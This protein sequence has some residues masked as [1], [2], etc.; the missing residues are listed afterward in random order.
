MSTIE[1]ITERMEF[2]LGTM[3]FGESFDKE[4]QKDDI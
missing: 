1:Q 3:R 4:R 2:E